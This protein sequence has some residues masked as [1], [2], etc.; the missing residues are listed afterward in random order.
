MMR[1]LFRGR[2]PVIEI[3]ERGRFQDFR[4]PGMDRIRGHAGLYVG[5]E[6][7]D[8]ELLWDRIPAR[9]EPVARTER[10]WRGVVT[11][12]YVLEKLTG[13]T[14]ELSPPKG[15]P[16]FQWRVLAGDF[17]ARSLV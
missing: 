2:V 1:W 16:L 5:R 14:P 4:D 9:R 8:R 15:S 11:D 10:Q 12:T 6:P 7:D 17:E 13:W 3:N